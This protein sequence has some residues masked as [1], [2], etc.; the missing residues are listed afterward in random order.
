MDL[1]AQFESY[2]STLG[3]RERGVG[4]NYYINRPSIK[5]R[6]GFNVPRPTIGYY[7]RDRPLIQSIEST[8]HSAVQSFH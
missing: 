7:S 5:L 4:M 1:M 8:V 2:A 3:L 6:I